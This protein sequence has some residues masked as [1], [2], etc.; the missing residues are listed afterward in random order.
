M[1]DTI[2]EIIDKA[3]V[4]LQEKGWCQGELSTYITDEKAYNSLFAANFCMIGA[5]CRSPSFHDNRPQIE[6]LC[7]GVTKRDVAS[8]NDRVAKSKQDAIDT[9]YFMKYRYQAQQ[10][11]KQQPKQQEGCDVHRQN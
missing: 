10:Q 5:L 1:E 3:I 8:Y 9:L 4:T 6:A 11:P 7:Y 2:P